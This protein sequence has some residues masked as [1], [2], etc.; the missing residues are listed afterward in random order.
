[1]I[2]G[3]VAIIDDNFYV[4]TRNYTFDLDTSGWG[5]IHLI[6]GALLVATG[7]GLFARQTWAG[8]TAIFLASV[9]RAGELLLH[10]LLPVLGDR[11]DRARRVG[12]LGADQAGRD[13]HLKPRVDEIRSRGRHARGRAAR[14]RARARAAA[15]A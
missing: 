12:D 4:V 1:V 10:P 14:G 3:L 13:P 2:A 15:L 9:E 5:W 8:L 11:R 7:I 6:L